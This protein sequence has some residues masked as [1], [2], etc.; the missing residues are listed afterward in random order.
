MAAEEFDERLNQVERA[1]KVINTITGNPELQAQAFGILFRGAAPAT[2]PKVDVPKGESQTDSQGMTGDKPKPRGRV[3]TATKKSSK[4]SVSQDKN[5]DPSP[6]GLQSWKEFVA[7]KQPP[8]Q[9]DKNTSAVFWLLEVASLTQATAGQVV[10]LYIDA[11]W[12][13]PSDP[14]NS[15]QQT[16]SRPGYLDTSDPDDLKL[17]PRG[18]AHI[19]ND[20]PT[21]AKA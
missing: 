13:L 16:A 6:A 9:Y 2:P 4:S 19:Q 5:L 11:G 17:T 8:T 7:E 15:L 10:T 1:L 12:K 20:L 18:F 3:G 14:K 21:V